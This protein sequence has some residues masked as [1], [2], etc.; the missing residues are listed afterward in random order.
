MLVE[1]RAH[2][3]LRMPHDKGEKPKQAEIDKVKLWIDQGAK[4]N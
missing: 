4:N 1:G 3:A 2:P